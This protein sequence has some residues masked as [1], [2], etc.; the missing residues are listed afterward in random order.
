MVMAVAQATGTTTTGAASASISFGSSTTS[1]SG[2][3]V[4]QCWNNMLD[5]A[6]GDCTDNKS[7]T[8]QLA[9]FIRNGIQE[10]TGGFYNTVSGA[11]RGASHQITCDQIASAGGSQ[12]IGI[13]EFTGQ[14]SST[15]TAAFH[16]ASFATGTDITSGFDVVAA[17]AVPSDNVSMAAYS[18]GGASGSVAVGAPTGYT[19]AGSQ[20]NANTDLV[21]GVF[22]KAGESGTPTVTATWTGTVGTETPR[23]LFMVFQAAAASGL[24][25]PLLCPIPQF[26]VHRM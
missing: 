2:I 20:G 22:Y 8:Y 13:V 16:S 10:G 14:D 24:D 1:G 9:G 3:G 18:I 19:A 23:E 17:A 5:S 15:A 12:Q 11:S 4:S 25:V 26:N 6:A 21:Y 7:N